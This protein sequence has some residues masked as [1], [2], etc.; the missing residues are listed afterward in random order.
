M[1][2]WIAYTSQFI[3]VASVMAKVY[4]Y[5]YFIVV[6]D[7]D[8]FHLSYELDQGL[9]QLGGPTSL[10]NGLRLKLRTLLTKRKPVKFK[11]EFII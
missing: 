4:K 6:S 1:K 3:C 10:E 9:K 11:L 7:S 5:L 2:A 8:E